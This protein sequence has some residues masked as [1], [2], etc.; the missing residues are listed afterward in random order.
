MNLVCQKKK[1]TSSVCMC[2]IISI[3]AFV[4]R[5]KPQNYQNKVG[6]ASMLLRTIIDVR[7][8]IKH[9]VKILPF[10]STRQA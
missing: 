4:D 7:D 1:K 6:P 9:F 10:F 3:S 5:L 8:Y 2:A